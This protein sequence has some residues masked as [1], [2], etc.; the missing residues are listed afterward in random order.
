MS[1]ERR[2]REANA[3]F[4]EALNALDLDAMDAVWADDAGAVCVHPGH[5]AI[6]GYERVRESWVLIFASTSSM[7]VNVSEEFVTVAGDVAWVACTEV[8]SLMLD[9]ELISASAHATNIFRRS[10]GTTGWRMVVHH[11]SPVPTRIINEEWPDV[12]N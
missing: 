4:Y 6:I 5:E 11:A 2:V 7:S 12:I 10:G 1:D 9:D 8:I 3:R